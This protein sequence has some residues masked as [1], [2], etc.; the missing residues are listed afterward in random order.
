M[1][2]S[3][4]EAKRRSGEV[5]GVTNIAYDLMVVLANKLEGI[6]AIE[7]YKLDADAA[8][9]AEVRAVLERIESRDRQDVDELR[10]HLITHLRRVQA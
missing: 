2:L 7:E 9:S 1:V 5:S 10:D 4:H 6:A 8:G 3:Q